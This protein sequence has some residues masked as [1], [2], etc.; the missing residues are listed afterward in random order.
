MT[1]R[2]TRRDFL[3]ATL[4]SVAS[5]TLPGCKGGGGDSDT[6]SDGTSTGTDGTGTEGTVTDGG[7]TEGAPL[8]DGAAYFPQAIASGDP[9]P[10]SVILWTR[11]EDPELGEVD[12]TLELQ[13][14]TDPEFT[15]LVELDAAS[16]EI[17]ALAKYDRCAKA[18]VR[19]LQPATT[20]HY[21]FVLTRADGRYASPAGR[22]RTAPE[23]DADV[24][25]RF[26]F[27]SCQ[28]YNGRYYNSYR[29]LLTQELDFFVHLG[30]YVYETTG[31]PTFQTTDARRVEFSDEAG[32][33]AFNAGT[34]KQYF[35]ARSLSN[36]RELYR[37]YRSDPA[38]RRVHA[39]LPMIAVWDDHEFSDDCHGATATYT[40]GR[41]DE[42]DEERRKHANQAW[43]EYMPVDFADEGFAY[44]PGRPYPDDIR[45]YRDFTFGKHLHLVMTDLRSYRPDHLIPEDAFPGAVIL[46][47][48]DLADAPEDVKAKVVPY[49]EDIA[50][51]DG[52]GLVDALATAAD[53][54]GFDPKHITG[55]MDA[56]YVNDLLAEIGDPPLDE[57]TLAE[58]PRGLAFRHVG[59]LSFHGSIGARYL[60]IKDVYDVWAEKR[61]A[62]SQGQSADV[63]GEAQRDWFIASMTGAS[64]TFKVWG[65]E[66]SLMPL[67]LDLRDFPVDPFNQIFYMNV[68]QWDGFFPYRNALLRDLQDAGT[69]VA[70]TGDIHAFYAGTPMDTE[71]PNTRLVELV[72][73]AISS[74]TFQSLLVLQVASDPVLS[75]TPGA[76]NLA[77]AIDSLFTAPG[78][79]P[80]LGFANS[81]EHGFVS[82]EVDGAALVATYHMVAEAESQT[83][84]EGD[85]DAV[86]GKFHTERFK[87]EAGQREIFREFD[88]AWRRWDPTANDWV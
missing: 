64:S 84:Y 2:F 87:V 36:Y 65:N 42:H 4:V 75:M 32:A 28:D 44:D 58:L 7:D 83:D 18:K 66:F 3:R 85:D 9:R 88:G 55:P 79:N 46:T 77:A 12:A 25:V 62:E 11:V 70:I 60:V 49:I 37:Q 63:M 33:I 19:G 61:F 30:D 26:A 82:V 38:L 20:Y 51:F 5:A 22:T 69:V 54:L 47:E 73:G 81:S 24:P 31:D 8:L 29:R 27:A 76:S 1:T 17:S 53:A 23:R 68:D 57:A 43:F 72:G 6:D 14:A 71:D 15:A 41:E 48:A 45:I 74:T 50:A 80:H 59:K 78:A 35:A 39:S 56:L 34:E 40:D 52:G 67:Q 10:D 86:V 16:A 21:R 13:V